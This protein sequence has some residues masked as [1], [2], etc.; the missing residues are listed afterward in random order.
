[1]RLTDGTADAWLLGE[2]ADALSRA[3]DARVRPQLRKLLD[4]KATPEPS[5][6]KVIAALG[7]SDGTVSDAAAIRAAYPRFTEKERSAALGAL[8]NIG[9]RASVKWM[10]DRA[11]DPAES[12]ALRRSATQ[13]AARAGA[14]RPNS[15]RFTMP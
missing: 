5:R 10:L 11:R 3:N 2:A 7:N 6:V 14:A 8:A 15:P 1:M 12:M 13:R 9:D 4:N